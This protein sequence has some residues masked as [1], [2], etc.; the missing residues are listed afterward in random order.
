MFRW[1][2]LLVR[3]GVGIAAQ[4]SNA[5]E[6]EQ[7]ESKISVLDRALNTVSDCTGVLALFFRLGQR[8][9]PQAWGNG[10]LGV[11]LLVVGWWWLLF[12]QLD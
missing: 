10:S 1:Y 9:V 11:L 6:E 8:G 5:S 3:W 12:F 2:Q 7:E 4:C